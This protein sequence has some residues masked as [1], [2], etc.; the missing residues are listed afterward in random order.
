MICV[1]FANVAGHDSVLARLQGYPQIELQYLE[2]LLIRRRRGL[3]RSSEDQQAFF[4][5]HVVRY[6]ELLCS[7]TPES[8]LPFL[9]E[10]EAL[11]LRE[12]LEL[13]RKHCVIDGSVYLLEKTGDFVAVLELLLNDYRQALEQ[14]HRSFTEVSEGNRA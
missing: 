12:C 4:D 8:V 5:S 11:P 1:Q 7:L 13:C 6:F 3:W 2:T 10:N 9:T 14:L